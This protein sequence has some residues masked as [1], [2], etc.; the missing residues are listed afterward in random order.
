MLSIRPHEL[1]LW[2]P[3][4]AHQARTSSHSPSSHSAPLTVLVLVCMSVSLSVSV[5][6]IVSVLFSC[7]RQLAASEMLFFDS[8]ILTDYG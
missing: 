3:Y 6:V 5:S 2:Q 1:D 4:S 8:H 7:V